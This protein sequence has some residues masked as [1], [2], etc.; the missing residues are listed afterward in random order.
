MLSTVGYRDLKIRGETYRH[1][2]YKRY[3]AED[4]DLWLFGT[5]L[6]D[7]ALMTQIGEA[8]G[9]YIQLHGD[10]CLGNVMMS[11]GT[12]ATSVLPY[13]GDINVWWASRDS[14]GSLDGYLKTTSVKPTHILAPSA[15]IMEML[16]ERGYYALH[17][18]FGVGRAFKPLNLERNGLGYAGDP[19]RPQ[20]QLDAIVTPIINRGDF[21]WIAKKAKDEWYTLERLNEWYNTKRIVFAMNRPIKKT[22]GHLSNRFYETFASGTPLITYMNNSLDESFPDYPYQSDSAE[23]TV[24]LI[25]DV[26]GDYERHHEYFIKLSE[27][28]RENHSMLG[29]MTKLMEWLKNEM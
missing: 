21:E 1:H 19:I 14:E 16:S 26:L 22:I 17:L 15:T 12:T 20:E 3:I 7:V 4:T 25:D 11:I 29:R 24:E 5:G 18:P 27:E 8:F 13:E 28:V 23:R 10:P 6:G 2:H 9:D